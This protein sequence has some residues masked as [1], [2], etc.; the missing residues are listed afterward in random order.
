VSPRHRGYHGGETRSTMKTRSPG[1]GERTHSSTGEG[2][3]PVDPDRAQQLQ[4][5]AHH[6]VIL[7][8]REPGTLFALILPHVTLVGTYALRAR[9]RRSGLKGALD[10]V[11]RR[12]DGTLCCGSLHYVPVEVLPRPSC[13][14]PL[15]DKQTRCKSRHY[16]VRCPRSP[17]RYVYEQSH[18]HMSSTVS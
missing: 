14:L 9:R 12:Q 2:T 16:V 18:I 17:A 15:A 5:T 10:V 6:P 1:D 13:S 8:R 7:T 4:P 3:A 11:E